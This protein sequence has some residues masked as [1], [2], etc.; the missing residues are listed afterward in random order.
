MAYKK[1]VQR[2]RR[3]DAENRVA[4]AEFCLEPVEEAVCAAESVLLRRRGCVRRERAIK[5]RSLHY[6][7]LTARACGRDDNGLHVAE[8]GSTVLLEIVQVFLKF[9]QSDFVGQL[10][11]VHANTGKDGAA[12]F[13]R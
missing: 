7:P 13:D 1:Y 4:P 10:N 2:I 9:Q 6:G 11:A 12:S 3:I 8:M 5:P